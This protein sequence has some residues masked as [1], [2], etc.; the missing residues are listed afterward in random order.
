MMPSSAKPK[1]ANR[2][3]SKHTFSG[4]WKKGKILKILRKGKKEMTFDFSQ[5]QQWNPED[6]E[7]IT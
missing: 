1:K 2:P 3:M 4:H 6:N 7:A 5:H